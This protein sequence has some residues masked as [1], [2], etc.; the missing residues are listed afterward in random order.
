MNQEYPST[1]NWHIEND[2]EPMPTAVNGNVRFLNYLLDCLLLA[3]V[4]S[5]VLTV[6]FPNEVLSPQ[7]SVFL[8][9]IYSLQFFYYFTCEYF[10]GR[11]VAKILTNCYVATEY[12]EKPTFLAI[13]IRT[14]CRY[15]PFE[16][17]SFLGT[18]VGWHDKISKTYVVRKA[19]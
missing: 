15:I 12:N 8:G 13:L 17:F 1:H 4:A 2:Q 19:A 9:V 11:T 16:Y 3:L 5:G 7:S 14:L 10:F 6:F 18:G